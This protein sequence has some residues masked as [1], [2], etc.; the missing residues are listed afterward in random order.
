MEPNH[1]SASLA[2]RARIADASFPCVGAK[3]ALGQ[4]NISF[5]VGG[6]LLDLHDDAAL[7]V[8]RFSNDTGC[9]DAA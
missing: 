9:S 3:S 6:D 1:Q 7:V 5:E 4:D 2:F 8:R